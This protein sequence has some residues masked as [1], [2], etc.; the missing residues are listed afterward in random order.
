MRTVFKF[1]PFS[2]KQKI[3]LTWWES[4]SPYK[5][6]DGIIADGAVRSGKTVSMALSFVNWG[7][8]SFN[9][10]N[11]AFCGK[12]I[13]SLRR[14]VIQPLKVML[15]TRGYRV[16]DHRSENCLEI[17]KGRVTNYFYMFGG[18][19][20]SSQDL[21]QG[22]T[23]AGI[24]FDEVALMPESFVNQGTARC[25][26]DG[27]KFWFNCN[28][29]GP[30][31]WFKKNWIDNKKIKKLIYLHFTMDDNL[32]LTEQT[33]ARYRRA[34]SGIFFKRYILGLWVLAEGIIYDMFSVEKHVKKIKKYNVLNQEV[35][36]FL[37]VSCDYGTQNPCTFGLYGVKGDSIHLVRSY[38]YDGRKTGKQRTDSEYAEDMVEWLDKD[39]DDIKF[40]LVDPSAASFIAELMKTKYR[41]P[42]ILKAKNDVKN[43][44]RLVSSYLENELFTIDPSNEEDIREFQSYLWDEKASQRG[45]EAP[46]KENDHCLDRTRYAIYTVFGGN[47]H[48]QY[49][50]NVYSRG[51]KQTPENIYNKIK[52]KKGVF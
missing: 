10:Q 15:W 37:F 46:V 9:G 45:E 23:L 13:G 38:Y 33:K 27:A 5:D 51:R 40:I 39:K 6:Y 20:E 24:F 25:S 19:D 43:G 21:I 48:L 3:V 16:K 11:L 35:F 4:N 29:E 28:P 12:T 52:N 50:P 22:I 31:H 2:I 17:T 47:L 14:N 8:T 1:K 18:K 49:S 32:S 34:Y 44:I 7:M 42:D 26:V 41:L 36:D 30:Y